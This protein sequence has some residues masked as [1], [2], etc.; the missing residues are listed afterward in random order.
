M[1]K[2]ERF[3][4][5][6]KL[7]VAAGAAAGVVA[8]VGTISIVISPA[9]IDFFSSNQ[10]SPTTI[11]IFPNLFFLNFKGL[12]MVLSFGGSGELNRLCVS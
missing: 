6:C 5:S 11:D 3:N 10:F 8:A 7:I 2:L 4:F 12:V 9:A 1:K